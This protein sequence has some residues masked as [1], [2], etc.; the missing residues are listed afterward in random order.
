MDLGKLRELSEHRIC[1][2]C[3]AEFRTI[4][5]TK[6]APEVPALAQFSDHSTIHQPT[7]AQWVEA[8]DRIQARK[9]SAG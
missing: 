2:Q 1:L 4:P 9:K 3:G 8:Y 7:G 5:A 6:D